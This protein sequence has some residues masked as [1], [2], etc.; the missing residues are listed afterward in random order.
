MECQPAHYMRGLPQVIGMK[1]KYNHPEQPTTGKAY[2]KSVE[3]LAHTEH[4]QRYLEREFPEN[5]DEMTK[6]PLTRRTFL[7][8]MG[9]SLALAGVG[10]SACRRPE[11]HLVPYTKTPE[12]I[13]AG[14]YLPYATAHPRRNG[15]VPLLVSTYDGRPTKIEG[16]PIHPAS[17]G[18]TDAYAQA[19]V[20]DLYD[21]DRLRFFFK[22]GIESTQAE[23]FS[24]LEKLRAEWAKD[25]GESLAIIT[26]EYLSPTMERLRGDLTR[27]YPNLTW[28]TWEPLKPGFTEEALGEAF[29]VGKTEPRLRLV[30]DLSKAKVVVSLD[31][32]F[33][34]PSEGG[35]IGVREFSNRRRA[36]H[37]G[38]EMN[39]LYAAEPRYTLTG[40]MADHRLRIPASQIG[41]FLTAIGRELALQGLT[42]TFATLIDT[43]SKLSL[44]GQDIDKAVHELA[45]DLKSAGSEG[46]LLVGEHQPANVQ[47]LAI[48]INEALGAIGTTLVPKAA[49][50]VPSA[51]LKEV[52]D[53]AKA[54]KIKTVIVFGGNP[55]YNAPA[56]LGF[57]D[58]FKK[59]PNKIHH[60]LLVNETSKVSNWVVPAAHYLESWGDAL[61]ED[62][63]YL[64]IQPMILPLYDGLTT[65]DLLC[66]LQNL[67]V[68]IGPEQVKKTFATWL[69][70]PRNSVTTPEMIAESWEKHVHDGGQGT[71]QY[72]WEFQEPMF[73]PQSLSEFLIKHPIKHSVPSKDNIEIVK[74]HDYSMDDGRYNNN[75]WMQE[76][77]DPITKMTWEN[78][79]LISPT[80]AKDFDLW[81]GIKFGPIEGDAGIV[82][83]DVI[84][85]TAHGVTITAP[86]LIVPGHADYSITLPL[87]YGRTMTGRVGEGSGFDV[88]PIRTTEA[89]YFETGATIKKLGHHYRFAVTQDHF[90]ME[91]RP[92]IKEAPKDYFERHPDFVSYTEEPAA[93]DHGFYNTPPMKAVH[94]WAMSIDLTTCVGCNACVIAC[95]AENNIPIVG[96]DQVMRGREMLWIR[97]D[98]YFSSPNEKF[99]QDNQVLPHDPQMIMQPLPCM[100]C[101]NAP[102]ETVCPVNATVHNEEGLNVMVYN[103]CIGTR[104]C[105]NNCPYKV[106]HF[107]YFDFNQRPIANAKSESLFFGTSKLYEGP[108][109]PK[110]SPETIMLQKNPNVT[111]RMRGVMEKCTYCVQRLEAAKIDQLDKA[112][113]TPNVMIPTD[114]VQTACQQACP[115]DAIIFGNLNDP[116]SKVVGLKKLPHNYSLLAYLN[117]RPRTTYLARIRNPNPKMPG[118]EY[119]GMAQ[120]K[121]LREAELH[122]HKESKE[123]KTVPGHAAES[124]IQPHGGQS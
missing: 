35:L 58:L 32:D 44:P 15:A 59:I 121:E 103:R 100:Q 89:P 47:A 11:A 48:A 27:L 65:V 74:A 38:A 25:Q 1:R 88:Y 13:V 81:S 50:A 69:T 53:Q 42:G 40:A 31:H 112:G 110:G 54:G 114:S 98:R 95:Q 70:N 41:S 37:P 17:K 85:I 55:V 87:G 99:V 73:N 77:P 119:I 16:N 79:A 10:L 91:G 86:V 20:L 108:L 45:A 102:C 115:S 18:K 5:A 97:I 49:L 9:A 66:K 28:S 46:I 80:M 78:A 105:S 82:T 34:N 101:E 39:R 52:A 29:A 12:W 94:E 116:A 92:L 96:K 26:E 67:P 93:F 62:G 14:R 23:F 57:V 56:D 118:A 124:T 2:W 76:F 30:P 109:A 64:S 120:L 4:F 6:D 3:D 68:P 107:N 71:C 43:A 106:R 51:S 21:P 113:P 111:V 8:L 61:A 117:T 22:D 72:S 63:S 84:E 7:K 24:A 90:S 33:L 104:Y 75:G 83:G 122:E 19:S 36:L 60:T 123:E